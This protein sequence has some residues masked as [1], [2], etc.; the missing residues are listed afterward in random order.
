MMQDTMMA[1]LFY[2]PGEVRYEE[3][4]LPEPGPGEL[5]VKINTALTCGTDLKCFRRGHPV[6]LKRFPSPFGHEFAGTIENI[7]EGV[8]HFELGDRVVAA[9]S[10][11]CYDCYYCRKGSHNLCENL[12]LLNGAYADYILVPAQIASYNTLHL[13]DHVSFEKAAFT[14]PLSVCVRAIE[15]SGVAAGDRVGIIGL[16]SIGQLLV[17]VAKWKGAHVTAMARNPMKLE[18]AS[19]FGMADAVVNLREYAEPDEIRQHF[20]PEGNGF[21]VV[22]EAVGLPETWESAI[23]LVRRG[24]RVNL[25]GGCEAGS[26]ISLDTRRI[27]YDEITLLSLFHHTPYYFKKAL[28]L[29]AE[30]VIDP[31]YLITTQMPLANLPEAL[32]MVEAGEA[33]K[34]ALKPC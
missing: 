7:G 15:L 24:G 21:D 19:R 13:P 17:R 1:A 6:L 14:E 34:V 9:N 31:T 18:T 11:P 26:T 22:I 12:D 5:L 32:A 3:T 4:T 27:H 25:F 30:G 23:K 10:A 28:D 2:R 29:M 8:S 33:F 20:T 16:G